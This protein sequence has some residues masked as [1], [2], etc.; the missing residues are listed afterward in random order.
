MSQD[1]TT[2]SDAKRWLI[3]F[4]GVGGV[5]A[6]L[7]N[8]VI[9]IFPLVVEGLRE[10]SLTLPQWLFLGAWVPF[11]WFSEGYRGFQSSFSPRVVARGFYLAEHRRPLHIALAPL[12]CMGFFH[13]DRRTIIVAWSVTIG[14]VCAVLLVGQLTQPWRGILDLGVI[15]GLVWGIGVIGVLVIRGRR[16][17]SDPRLPLI[18]PEGIV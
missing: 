17:D 9:G 8:A 18:R 3:L 1:A 15:V 2:P 12:F 7:L 10:Y 11:M 4:W 5:V 14:V 13:A 6:I 16:A